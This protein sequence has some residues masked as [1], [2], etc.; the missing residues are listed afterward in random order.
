MVLIFCKVD[1]IIH[2]FSLVWER[3][4]HNGILIIVLWCIRPKN[5][6]KLL[7]K[8]GPVLEEVKILVG[9]WFVNEGLEIV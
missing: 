5:V 7:D 2:S 4:C 8:G 9:I 1:E 6:G 3:D